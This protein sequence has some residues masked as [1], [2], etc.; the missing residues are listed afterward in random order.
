MNTAGIICEYNPLHAG[1]CL[2]M[3]HARAGLG[4]ESSVICVMSG[5][6]VQR[7]DFALTHRMARA[8]AAV[9][10]GADL[11]LELPLPWSVSSAER[12]AEGG[13]RTLAATGV[14]TH[15]AFG[16]E[17]GDAE[18]LARV[19]AGLRDP[20]FSPLLR[21]EL[22]TG[23]SFAAARQRAA[24]WLLGR[25]YGALLGTPNNILGIEYCK[26]LQATCA[27]IRPLTVRREGAAHDG[28]AV[29]GIASASAIRQLLQSGGR[30]RALDL[31]APAM[32]EV[33]LREEGAGRAPVF[34]ET[35]QRSVLAK[36][37][38]MTREE[39]DAL[40]EGNEGL[41]NR[42]FSASRTAAT[43]ADLL[44]AAKTKRYAYA[45]LRRMVLWA[46]LGLKPADVPT[47]V[48]YLRVLAANDVGCALLSR[49]K[50][51]ASVPV[52]TKPADVRKLSGAAQ[53]LFALEA[54]AAD[55]YA[56]AYPN[57]S[58]ATG[59]GAWREVP[60]ICCPL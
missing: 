39:F 26:S 58:A 25:E 15:L 11:V 53:T 14:V 19:A 52:L 44:G 1:H 33:F 20:A 50:K 24:E 13:V 12:F 57:L 5:N 16:S 2:L 40:D 38:T 35:C 21:R 43:L 37:R 7:G 60:V 42:L 32:R 30:E 28:E 34:V 6:F 51:T 54:R 27:P 48:P 3:K 22:K 45:R 46:Y 17:C 29:D 36:L 4:P 56:L 18:A 8:E 59:G 49:M 41:G 47:E 9:K 10:S 55:L 23:V 31:M